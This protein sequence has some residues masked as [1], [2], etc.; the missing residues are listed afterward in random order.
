[1]KTLFPPR[2]LASNLLQICNNKAAEFL[3]ISIQAV[4]IKKEIFHLKHCTMDKYVERRISE[5]YFFFKRLP[6]ELTIS[7]A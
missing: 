3:V 4:F 5:I 2:V 6:F 7:R 1:M